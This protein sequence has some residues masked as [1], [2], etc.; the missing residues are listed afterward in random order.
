MV[1][2]I[3]LLIKLEDYINS[4]FGDISLEMPDNSQN[5]ERV[6]S[7]APNDGLYKDLEQS[8]NKRLSAG[9]KQE[10]LYD[11]LLGYIKKLNRPDFYFK[12]G[13]K[14]D[15]L[16]GAKFCRYAYIDK[17]T[18]SNI[19]LDIGNVRKETLLKLVIALHLN[20]E[21]A[22]IVMKKGSSRFVYNDFRDQL[23]L[24]LLDIKC[25]EV[26]VI[27]DVLESFINDGLPQHKF[28]N[29]YDTKEIKQEKKKRS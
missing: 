13:T 16:N 14:K 4:R 21:D 22:E 10:T 25:Y 28:E 29:I 9:R 8:L 19:Q 1:M 12:S 18:W 24:A 7:I 11:M 6:Y 2:N 5:A 17:S 15:E 23:I 3:K 27:Y 26:D 20:E